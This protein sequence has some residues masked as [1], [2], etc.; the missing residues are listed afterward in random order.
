MRYRDCS[1]RHHLRLAIG[2][3]LVF[4]GCETA[5]AFDS[6]AGGETTGKRGAGDDETAAPGVGLSR[7]F[8]FRLIVGGFFARCG[9]IADGMLRAVADAVETCDTARVVD[10]MI[11]AVDTRSL[12]IALAFAAAVTFALVY[13]WLEQ[14]IFRQIAEDC[15]HGAYNV[16][17]IAA[18]CP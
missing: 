8:D 5:V 17:V 10:G 14:R 18:C 3:F 7:P 6:G 2:T 13:D 4:D 1:G 15:S 11:M 16:A 9:A 12:A